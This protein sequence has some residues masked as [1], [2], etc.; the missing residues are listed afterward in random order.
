MQMLEFKKSVL[1]LGLQVSSDQVLPFAACIIMNWSIYAYLRCKYENG[2]DAA[3]SKN[4]NPT[5]EQLKN[6]TLL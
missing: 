2:R 4:L 3:L 1:A 5:A 6:Q